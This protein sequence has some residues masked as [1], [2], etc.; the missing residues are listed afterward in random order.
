MNTQIAKLISC[1]DS[2]KNV[3]M[4]QIDKILNDPKMVGLDFQDFNKVFDRGCSFKSQIFDL[5][6]SI[7]RNAAE[8]VENLN[9]PAD[10]DIVIWVDG[11]LS[12]MQFNDIISGICD[13]ATLVGETMV[14]YNGITQEN[15]QIR[16]SIWF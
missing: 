9:I 11:N 7:Y 16:I 4:E 2:E 12:M 5:N 3:L 13:A 14:S 1:D 10:T 8:W 15:D 6:K